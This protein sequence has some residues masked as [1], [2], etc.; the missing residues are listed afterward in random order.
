MYS[1]AG[2]PVLYSVPGKAQCGKRGAAMSG[3]VQS[4]CG[5]RGA[6]MSGYVLFLEG[7]STEGSE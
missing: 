4:Q 6:A 2:R 7:T 5:E 1:E 3:Y